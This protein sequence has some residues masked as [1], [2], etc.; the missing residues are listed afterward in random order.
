MNIGIIGSGTM[1]AGMAQVASQAGNK[2]IVIDNNEAALQKAAMQL[3]TSLQKLS[4]K[5]KITTEK[6]DDIMANISWTQDLSSLQNADLVIEAIVEKLEIKQKL[7]SDL[8]KIVSPTCILA[9]NTSSLSIT[10]IAASCTHANRVTGIHFFN[11][12]PLMEL[13]EIIPALQSDKEI[14]N[15]AREIIDS[16]GKRTVMVKDTPGFIVN[17]IARPFYSEAI[18][19]FEEGFASVAEIDQAMKVYGGFRMGPFELMD[20]IGHD[21]NYTVTETVWTAFYFDPR[22][23]P[24]FTQK[25]L[26]EAKWYG[27]KSGRGFYDYAENAQ[28]EEINVDEEK[29]KIISNRIVMMLINEAA[30]ALYLNVASKED[31]DTAMTKGVNYPKGLLRWAD[32]IGIGKCVEHLDALYNEYHEDRYRC[33]PLL[34]KMMQLKQIFYP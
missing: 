7:F 14:V 18:R 33:S 17:R 10:S 13:V 5:G 12:A 30:N 19:L 34:R 29:G 26:V 8:E 21:V 22:Y 15:K 32:E 4:D 24:S 25:R 31:I 9:S 27:R 23:T 2:V 28:Q 11:P 20:L 6:A 1:G 3:K 16:M